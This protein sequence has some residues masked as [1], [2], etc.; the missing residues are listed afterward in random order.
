M[1]F[2]HYLALLRIDKT[3]LSSVI[4][5]KFFNSATRARANL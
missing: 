2:K 5:S 3:D 4:F 1:G